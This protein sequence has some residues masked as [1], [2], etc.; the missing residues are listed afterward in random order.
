LFTPNEDGW[1]KIADEFE[2]KWLM[3]HCVGAL[4]GKH[5]VHQVYNS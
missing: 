4:D 5:V 2:S 1:V 3:P